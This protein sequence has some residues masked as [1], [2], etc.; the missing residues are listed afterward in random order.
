MNREFL[1]WVILTFV[2]AGPSARGAEAPM[3]E[4]G[5]FPLKSLEPKVLLP[6]GSEFR[7]WE[8]EAVFT[9]A[10][11]VDPAHPQASDEGP[12]T[13]ER[14]FKTISRAAQ[15]LQ[16]GERVV[17]AS[18]VYRERVRPARGG[19][20]PTKM[21]S[22]EAAPGASVVLKGSKVFAERWMP[23][24]RDG[25]ASSVAWQAPLAAKYFGEYNPF[26]TENVT[27][28]QFEIMRQWAWDLRGQVPY[29][30][31]RGL[32]FQEGKLLQQVARYEELAAR[33][34]TY[35]VDRAAKALHVHPL[36]GGDPNGRLFEITTERVAFGPEQHGL[37]FI[38]VKGFTV[39][40]VGNAFP[41]QQEGAISTWRGHHW[42]IE[43]NT[44]RWANGVGIDVGIQAG[45]WPQPPV[46]GHHIV[47]RNVVEDIGVCGIAGIGVFSE[48][49][50]LIEDNVLR[51]CAFH[52]VERLYET[53]GIK[54]HINTGCLIRRNLILDTQH[55]AGIW[56]DWGNAN[57]RCTGNVIVGTRT[58][59]HGGIFIEASCRPNLIDH[60]VI[61]DTQGNGLYEHDCANQVFAHN[62]LGRCTGAAVLLNGK[63]TD[64]HLY[65]QPIT[66]GRHRVVNNAFFACG[67]NEVTAHRGEPSEVAGNLA[68]G[69]AA[70]LDRATFT[71]TWSARGPG[72]AT[73]PLPAITHDFFGAA[74]PAGAPAPGPFATLPTEPRPARL[75][76]GRG[77]AQGAR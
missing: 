25:K 26:D 57:S 65:G 10:Y 58:Q 35:W 28:E 61:W 63:V 38:R 51:R 68:E 70:E 56:M 59:W 20:S 39:E 16:P 18:G 53:G 66:A 76:P 43:Q 44:V 49:G 21:I 7:T 17:V 37:G 24:T 42:I 73:V 74:R 41:M 36:G 9:K 27:A 13:Q 29:V 30:L 33:A 14:P 2:L 67:K 47:R 22:Y 60:N 46:V 31:P 5:G 11:C 75:W 19:E 15:A 8:A 50:L 34:G 1:P 69:I 12:G 54:T 71:L 23:S 45:S 77:N 64:R 4:K 6:D 32:V 40:Q 62:F 48:F 3:S 52:P 55:G 72:P